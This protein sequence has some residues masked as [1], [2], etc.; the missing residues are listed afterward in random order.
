MLPSNMLYSTAVNNAK[1][2]MYT[3]IGKNK[4]NGV[5]FTKHFFE[6]AVE[7]NIDNKIQ[8]MFIMSLKALLDM[9]KHTYST[10]A[11]KI[12]KKGIYVIAEVKV[13]EITNKRFLLVKTCYDSDIFDET[14]YDV[15][16]KL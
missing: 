10:Y 3:L 7:R 9:R 2:N 13:G 16:L 14:K 4:I 15:E 12:S 11:Y 5:H 1:S 8:E 6:R